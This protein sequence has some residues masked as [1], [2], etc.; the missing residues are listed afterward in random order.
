MRSK[1]QAEDYRYFPEP[2]LVPLVLTQSYID[3]IRRSARTALRRASN[4]TSRTS[5]SPKRPQHLIN[6]KTLCRLLRRGAKTLSNA[7]RSATGSTVEFAGRLKDTGQ[8]LLDSGIPATIS[9]N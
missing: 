5:S 1:E 8:N 7:K 6:E 2:D 4:A 9:P 3:Q